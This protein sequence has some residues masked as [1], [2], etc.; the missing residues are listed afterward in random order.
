MSRQA[1]YRRRGLSERLAYDVARE[2]TQRD[3]V[4]AHARDELG[5]D[6]EELANPLQARTPAMRLRWR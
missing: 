6:P 3:P 4:E 5:I 1:I 2:L